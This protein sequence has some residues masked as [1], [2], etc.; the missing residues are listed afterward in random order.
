MN[1]LEIFTDGGCRSNPGIGGWGFYI[2]D[3]C[4]AKSYGYCKQTTNNCMELTA[5]LE[6]LKFV[7]KGFNSGKLTGYDT[8]IVKT[9]SAYCIN[10]LSKWIYRWLNNKSLPERKNW[11]LIYKIYILIKIFSEKGWKVKFQHVSGHSGVEGNEIADQ[12]AN[13]AMDK[14]APH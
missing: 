12:L 2:P 13:K 1:I 8:I 5:V 4:N 14:L 9:D 10:V 6:A 11:Q 7:N 3:F